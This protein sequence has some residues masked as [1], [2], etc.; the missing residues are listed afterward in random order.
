MKLVRLIKRFEDQGLPP[1]TLF[2]VPEDDLLF[3]LPDDAVR[4]FLSGSFPGWH[5][6]REE[7]RA[8][9]GR[10]PS[11]SVDWKRYAHEHYGLP[12]TTSDGV[13]EVV[14]TLDL[15]GVDLKSIRNV[16]DEVITWATNKPERDNSSAAPSSQ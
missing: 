6:T 11:D 8:A 1:P 14:R 3:G 2:G 10:G 7:C 9:E 16:V 5:E 13:R 4:S 12:I 15:A